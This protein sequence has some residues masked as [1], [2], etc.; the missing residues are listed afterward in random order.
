MA[1]LPDKPEAY[2]WP[3]DVTPDPPTQ[4]PIVLIVLYLAPF[5]LLLLFPTIAWIALLPLALV[6][7]VTSLPAHRRRVTWIYLLTGLVSFAPWIGML[8][9]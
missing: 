5:V 8:L 6:V 7:R 9:R 4:G 3:D 2:E 1:H